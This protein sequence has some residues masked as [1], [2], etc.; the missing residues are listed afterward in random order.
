MKILI[1]TGIYPPDIGGPAT[2]SKNLLEAFVDKGH[3]VKV[4]SFQIEKRLPT[5]LR[6]FFYGLRI[7]PSVIESGFIIC[8][9][10]FSV[11]LPV[12]ILGK[13]FRKKIILRTGGDFL[14]EQYVER[15]GDMVLLR[16][17]YK[18]S[19]VKLNLKERAILKFIKWIFKNV[20][21]VVFSTE[22]QRNI[23]IEPYNLN[24]LK[25]KII[26]NNYAGKVMSNL[27]DRKVFMAG[28]RKLKWKNLDLLKRAFD[29]AKQKNKDIDLDLNTYQPDEYKQRLEKSYATIL[30]SLGDISPNM[31]MESVASGK[32]FILTKENGISDRIRDFGFLVDPKD[33]EQIAEKILDLCKEGVYDSFRQKMSEDHFVHSWGDIAD[34]FEKIM[35]QI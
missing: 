6:H 26:E 32:P 33:V 21:L 4:K 19:L 31:I 11:A 15:T 22:W 29:L 2:Y 16:D 34:E 12:T 25:T 27:S 3:K 35:K 17:F 23:F 24:L 13:I 10:T 7:L 20:N 28:T 30:A 14:W 8:M 18:Q 9:D 5:G 1:A